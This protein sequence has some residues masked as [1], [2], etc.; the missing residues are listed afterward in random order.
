METLKV[1]IPKDERPL[2]SALNWRLIGTSTARRSSNRLIWFFIALFFLHFQ[3][4]CVPAFSTVK[5]DI[6]IASDFACISR[7]FIY[8]QALHLPRHKH[9][10]R[11]AGGDSIVRYC[12]MDTWAMGHIAFQSENRIEISLKC[13][14]L[15]L[16]NRSHRTQFA[17]S[18]DQW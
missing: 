9:E 6:F 10:E 8:V 1:V 7:V 12:R 13:L 5:V 15:L 3:S 18:V 2:E 16:V 11:R 14:W 4:L 17:S